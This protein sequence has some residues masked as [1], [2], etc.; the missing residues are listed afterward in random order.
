MSSVEQIS[1]ILA[2]EVPARSV[3]AESAMRLR[4][5]FEP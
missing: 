2:G 4:D 3:N 5:H 1:S